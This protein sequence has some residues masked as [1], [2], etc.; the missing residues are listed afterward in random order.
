[1]T[2][3][4]LRKVAGALAVQWYCHPDESEDSKAEA[5]TQWKGFENMARAALEAIREPDGFLASKVFYLATSTAKAAEHE[6]RF[7]AMIDA[8][9]S[10]SQ[11]GK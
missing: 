5:A 8:I 4:M 6:E 3:T 9:L 1:M 11:E 7:T 10:Q 2:E